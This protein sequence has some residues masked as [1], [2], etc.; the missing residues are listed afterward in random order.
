MAAYQSD[1]VVKCVYGDYEE[2]ATSEEEALRL[3]EAHS[4]THP[5]LA[6]YAIAKILRERGRSEV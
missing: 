2:V 3:I 1:G 4:A 6:P 5:P